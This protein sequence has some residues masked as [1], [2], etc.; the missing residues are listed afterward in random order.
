[1]KK[2]TSL[3]LA[4]LL[5]SY[6]STAQIITD[7]PCYAI[8]KNYGKAN[9]LYGYSPDTELWSRISNTQTKNVTAIAT[10]SNNGILYAFESAIDITQDE[11]MFGFID[12]ITRD[13]IAI[14]SPGTANGDYGDVLLNN[15]TGL[16]YDNAN[17]IMYAVHN[18]LDFGTKTND[19]LFQIDISTGSFIPNAMMDVNGQQADYAVTEEVLENNDLEFINNISDIAFDPLNNELTAVYSSENTYSSIITI[20]EQ[21]G[22]ADATLWDL[23]T[24]NME[25]LCYTSEGHMYSTTDSGGT[26]RNIFLYIDLENL[27]DEIKNP[28]S[29]ID[30]DFES[31]DCFHNSVNLGTCTGNELI[32]RNNIQ[33]GL[34]QSLS[35]IDDITIENS[36]EENSIVVVA[37]E[38]FITI[39]NMAIPANSNFLAE[40]RP[41]GL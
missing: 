29:N 30:I 31:L 21:F 33:A 22:Y 35:V 39:E 16:T 12:P 28:I 10:D 6:F 3:L 19:L 4:F 7:Y 32:L 2:F 26:R 9:V 24:Y 34:Y 15:I 25:S 18:I 1:M 38:Q 37:A 8:A 11:G 5:Y 20:D 27:S 14:G 41:C 40:I 36:I 17:N 23:T 13:F